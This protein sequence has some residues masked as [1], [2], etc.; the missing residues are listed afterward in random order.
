MDSKLGACTRGAPGGGRALHFSTI[1][2]Y[3]QI[4]NLHFIIRRFVSLSK[5]SKARKSSTWLRAPIILP[6]RGS[7]IVR[8]IWKIPRRVQIICF[9]PRGHLC[10][11]L[12]STKPCT[13]CNFLFKRNIL[14]DWF[15][16]INLEAC[17]HSWKL[18][19]NNVS[20]ADILCFLELQNKHQSIHPEQPN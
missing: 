7:V 12:R 19:T 18:Q 14:F 17:N 1:N 13:D 10:G 20:Q 6:G 3:N 2:L 5:F 8:D 11:I 9:Y 15:L 4:Y 16:K